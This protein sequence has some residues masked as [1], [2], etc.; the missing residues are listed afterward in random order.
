MPDLNHLTHSR[1]GTPDAKY[2]GMDDDELAQLLDAYIKLNTPLPAELRLE[3]EARAGKLSSEPPKVARSFAPSRREPGP[4]DPSPS[5][6]LLLGPVEI[7]ASDLPE[8][9]KSRISLALKNPP[10]N[11]FVINESK[12]GWALIGLVG[13]GFALWGII[14]AADGYKWQPEDRA[15]CAAALIIVFVA[16]W[17]SGSYLFKWLLFPFKAQT[18]VNPFYFLSFRFNR[19]VAVP[20]TRGTAW[21][22]KHVKD[23][24]GSYSH[25]KFFF[26]SESGQKNTIKTTSIRLTND[27]IEGLNS[28]PEYLRSLIHRRDANAKY[29]LDLLYEWRSDPKRRY[30]KPYPQNLTAPAVR[31]LAVASLAGL[32]GFAVFTFVLEPYNKYRDDEIRWSIATSSATASG[33]RIYIASCP[34]GAHTYQARANIAA[35]YNTASENYRNSSGIGASAGV[36]AVIKML[37]YAN[38]TGRYKVFVEFA[39]DNEIPPSIET[40]LEQKYNLPRVVPIQSSFTTAMDNAR[41]N[42]ILQR[43]AASFGKI[44]PGDILLFEPGQASP[45]DISLKIDYTIHASGALYSP[46]EQKY[47]TKARRDW[48]T[49]ISFDWNF[50]VNIPGAEL[51][52]FRFSL[53]SEPAQVFNVA[54]SRTASTG[55]D[56]PLDPTEVYSAMADSAFTDFGSK[57]LSEL[58]LR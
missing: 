28:F 22:V 30:R 39:G 5:S 10:Q 23:S 12:L 4:R 53:K 47:L 43:V 11:T 44:I 18:L 25:S 2:E 17:Y 40:M 19:I 51:A 49:G 35:L 58:A 57:L 6:D 56:P 3:L 1:L 21:N 33:Y 27:L 32:L 42:G 13:A 52:N 48:Y 54:Y 36:E 41:E 50:L 45:E 55:E 37:E 31:N 8:I 14:D 20:F 46:E 9:T 7:L 26:T 24:R 16:A 29:S 38:T 15:I 34:E